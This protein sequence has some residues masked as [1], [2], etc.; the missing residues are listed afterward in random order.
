MVVRTLKRIFFTLMGAAGVALVLAALFLLT[1]TVQRSDDFDRLQDV[2]LAVNIA[3]GFIL[4]LI[5]IGNLWRLFHDYRENVPG[6]KLK[7]RMVGMF[8][9]LAVLP[10]LVVF[11]FSIQFINRGIDSWFNVQVE[12]GLDNALT[13]SRAAI[14]FRKRQ[15]LFAT[16]QVA[17]KLANVPDRQLVFELSMLRRE[18]GASEMTL[19]G[20]NNR[21]LAT[22]SDTA[23]AS[24]PKPLTEEVALQM[25]QNRPFVSLEPLSS[26]NAEIRTAIAFAYRFNRS[27]ES[28]T[29]QAHFPID[30]RLGNMISSVENSYS[31]Y[32]QLV[33]FR[34][35]L[36]DLLTVTLTF[37]L[38]LSLLAAI[39]GAFVLSRRLVAPIQDLVAGTR[40]VAMGDFD[41]KLP[42][43]TR[44]EIGF[45]ISSF[46]DMT[47]RLAT[48]RRE[49]TMSQALVEAERT[50]LEVILAR[51]STGVL[52]LE[53]DL[54]IRTAN[55]A[56]AGKSQR[57]RDS[58]SC[59]RNAAA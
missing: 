49:A 39:Y 43:P 57:R 25:Q 59:Q 20:D 42:T 15:Y 44:D 4:I 13:L 37:V 30:E 38:L 36:K 18:S 8:V 54:K 46:N 10:L 2:I 11:Y 1:Q 21:V 27:R 29:V 19:Y 6:A 31:E 58:R 40:A 17:Q 5:L 45:L 14:E 52:A 7:A 51:L 50:N 33:F 28:R 22:S 47:Q 41:T 9:G 34:E 32:Q 23:T 35:D 26:G 56:S 48:A 53:S 3:G 16:T 24:M 12:E 55:Q